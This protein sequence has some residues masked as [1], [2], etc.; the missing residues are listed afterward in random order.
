MQNPVAQPTLQQEMN[1]IK[2]EEVLEQLDEKM[3]REEDVPVIEEIDLP[4][5]KEIDPEL[6]AKALS[7]EVK[8]ALAPFLEPRRLQ[9][10]LAGRFSIKF[11]RDF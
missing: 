2:A 9:P 1:M 5:A 8:S 11:T 7:P 4:A 6:R 3:E 10:S